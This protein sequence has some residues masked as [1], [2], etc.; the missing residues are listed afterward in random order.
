MSN[1]VLNK[2]ID[3][4]PTSTIIYSD[5][6]GLQ[7]LAMSQNGQ[8][9]YVKLPQGWQYFNGQWWSFIYGM[10]SSSR[11]VTSPVRIPVCGIRPSGNLYICAYA[12]NVEVEVG[13]GEHTTY[14]AFIDS[15]TIIVGHGSA[16]HTCTLSGIL[17][18]NKVVSGIITGIYADER[19]LW[20]GTD[21][22]ITYMSLNRG[23]TWLT[24][25]NAR[26]VAPWLAIRDGYFFTIEYTAPGPDGTTKPKES[27]EL[28]S[29]TIAIIIAAGA[30][31]FALIVGL[32]LL[33]RSQRA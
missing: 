19:S 8:E 31:F 2:I 4:E 26:V 11:L 17:Q 21:A 12:N 15:S 22:Q 10:D 3:G 5:V 24:A 33:S 32:A 14:A 6:P 25:T 27:S 16:V 9:Y 18:L 28:S 30:I 23:Q 20:V 13:T 1:V 7:A 29:T